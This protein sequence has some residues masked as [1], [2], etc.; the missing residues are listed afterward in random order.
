MY[1]LIWK[2]IRAKDGGITLFN[3]EKNET[4]LLK[5]SAE[6]M[7]KQT[8]KDVFL[9]EFLI[10]S[11]NRPIVLLMGSKKG[12]W[13]A[14]NA[15][16]YHRNPKANKNVTQT[17]AD[18][19][20]SLMR[21]GGFVVWNCGGVVLITGVSVAW[22]KLA[23]FNYLPDWAQSRMGK[24]AHTPGCHLRRKQHPRPVL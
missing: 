11:I 9:W 23:F 6:L 8:D 7:D 19:L 15:V 24:L 22:H 12:R 17:R 14:Q 4:L 1:L 5:V 2:L 21:P 16:S 13:L 20:L 10:N 3:M 18:H